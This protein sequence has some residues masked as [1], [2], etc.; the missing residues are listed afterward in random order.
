MSWPFVGSVYF[1]LVGT[2]RREFLL[3][4]ISLNGFL[5]RSSIVTY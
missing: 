1:R 3:L 2:G 4:V 5:V